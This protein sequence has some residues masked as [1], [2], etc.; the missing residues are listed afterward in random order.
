[1]GLCT[2]L[3]R[4]LTESLAAAYAAG[5]LSAED[6]FKVAYHRG[7]LSHDIKT[8]APEKNGAMMAVG[9]SEKDVKPYLDKLPS[10]DT[11]VVACVNSP[12]NVTISGDSAAL[13]RLGDLLK[14]AS[15]FARRLKVE[16]AYHSPHMQVIAEDYLASIKD[17]K[18]LSPPKS[19][20]SMISS[21][22]GALVVAADLNASYWVR[23][24]VSPVQFVKACGVVLSAAPA[25][26]TRRRRGGL[27]IDTV[28][29]IGPHSALA[30]PLKQILTANGKVED[31]PYLSLLSRGQNAV[32]S[33]LETAG[34]LWT[35][36][37]PLD[38]LRVN[39]FEADPKSSTCLSDLPKYAWK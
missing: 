31:T 10:S 33:T 26:A 25:G 14:P 38:F 29:E 21:V 1:M 20:P 2:I 7:R 34:K 13:D 6:C 19:A 9:L 28:L 15:V 22:T 8:I 32:T 5:A 4:I 18:P 3:L 12:S 11:A 36:G 24:M 35:M 17:I 37:Q 39:A 16:N 23:N 30:G 27:A